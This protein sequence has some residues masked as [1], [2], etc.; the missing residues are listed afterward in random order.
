[1]SR[2][3]GSGSRVL[4]STLICSAILF[5][6]HTGC[7][8]R[9]SKVSVAE[10][11]REP[12]SGEAGWIEVTGGHWSVW[13]K[14]PD[15]V[16]VWDPV[17]GFNGWVGSIP[18]DDKVWP[19]LAPLIERHRAVLRHRSVGLLPDSVVYDEESTS[20]A[21]TRALMQREGVDELA[22]QLLDALARPHMGA[23]LDTNGKVSLHTSL[24][25]AGQHHLGALHST[26]RFLMSWAAFRME[27][28]DPESFVRTVVT[29]LHA[30]DH[31]AQP[32]MALNQLIQAACVG[33][34]VAVVG[35]ALEHHPGRLTDGDLATLDNALRPHDRRAFVWQGEVLVFED[36]ARRMAR[37]IRSFD[38][39][40]RRALKS[41]TDLPK[42]GDEALHTPRAALHPSVVRTLDLF[43]R[44]V[45]HAGEGSQTMPWALDTTAEDWF[46]SARTERDAIGMFMLDVLMPGIDRIVQTMRFRDQ[47]VIATRLALAAYRARLRTGAFPAS[48]DQIPGDLLA[49]APFDGFVGEPLRYRLENGI[50]LVYAVGQDRT[51]DGGSPNRGR[52]VLSPGETGDWVLFPRRELDEPEDDDAFGTGAG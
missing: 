52:F 10:P 41:K 20:W 45:R 47:S 13:S 15:G 14:R 1:M 29:I 32:P 17:G 46:E 38:I 44:A 5:L 22:L 9:E 28:G 8:V 18:E 2:C 49:G 37:S 39:G 26:V 50:P 25:G 36:E 33:A 43:E 42:P 16:M 6:N 3:D 21:H 35:W 34:G 51:D 48:I 27:S 19:V 31:A 24:L 23:P 7:T 11:A 12:D 4:R 30:A 40:E